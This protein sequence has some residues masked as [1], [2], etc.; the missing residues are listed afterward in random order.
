MDVDDDSSDLAVFTTEIPVVFAR[1]RLA[2]DI[3]SPV[4]VAV[5]APV[6]RTEV[7]DLDG[8]ASRI[9][10]IV[11]TPAPAPQAPFGVSVWHSAA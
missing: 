9:T 11:E 5:G 2:D 8:G 7:E 10:T 1:A 6:E 3:P 4:P